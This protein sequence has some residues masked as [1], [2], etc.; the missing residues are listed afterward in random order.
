MAVV[1]ILILVV[2]DQYSKSLA[3]YYLAGGTIRII[4]GFFELELTWNSGAAWNFLAAKSWGITLLSISSL[5]V[6]IVVLFYLGRAQGFKA[7]MIL[8]LIAAGGIG[9]LIDRIRF[10]R[11]TD[12]L[13]FNFGSYKFPVFNLAD[14]F[15]TIGV[16]LAILFLLLDHS[17]MEQI[18]GNIAPEIGDAE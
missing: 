2:L 15:V 14:A 9:N 13:S 1:T 18:T 12:F 7:K 6:S 3:E 10:G 16:I 5:I 17:F 8:V 4:P 11:V